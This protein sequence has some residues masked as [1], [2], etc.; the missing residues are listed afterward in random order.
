MHVLERG[1]SPNLR[2]A[3][4]ICS[5]PPSTT[6][7]A[8]T[9]GNSEVNTCNRAPCEQRGAPRLGPR[10]AGA[11]F[12]ASIE[13]GQPGEGG[14]RLE[15]PLPP[16]GPPGQRREGVQVPGPPPSEAAGRRGPDLSTRR[17]G[18]AWPWW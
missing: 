12:I 3:P 1:I 18:I 15:R 4:Y 2:K 7:V 16:R 11:V 9:P 13:L 6:E 8:D 10:S 14:G 5:D 17:P